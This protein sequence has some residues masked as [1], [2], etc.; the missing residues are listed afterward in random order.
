M[1]LGTRMREIAQ[2]GGR[3][4]VHDSRKEAQARRRRERYN[5]RTAK[6][7]SEREE[8]AEQ[9]AREA[10]LEDDEWSRWKDPRGWEGAPPEALWDK[11][12]GR[13]RYMLFNPNR[14][15]VAKR[16]RDEEQRMAGADEDGL[17]EAR[18]RGLL[19]MCVALS[20]DFGGFLASNGK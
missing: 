7:Q 14:G 11:P 18:W 8:R 15:T 16:T 4:E 5:R 10:V 17:A 12:S 9:K 20:I 6:E 19:D 13:A 2:V 1:A 3:Q